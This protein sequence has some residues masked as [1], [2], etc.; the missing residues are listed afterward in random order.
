MASTSLGLHH[1]D[2]R[3]IVVVLDETVSTKPHAVP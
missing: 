1:T 3:N 2:T